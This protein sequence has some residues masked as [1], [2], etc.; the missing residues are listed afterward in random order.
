MNTKT[1]KFAGARGS[2]A[3]NWY[4]QRITGIVL[5]VVLIGHYI[6]MHATPDSGHTYRAVM[7]RLHQPIW[8]I[9]DLS[10]VTLGLWH[11]L[12]GTWSVIRDYEMKPWLT[13]TLYTIIV[14]VAL[15]FWFLGLNTILSF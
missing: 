3:K 14:I 4:M 5:V 1:F 12:N 9:I 8:K 10:F 13:T 15:A 2:G 6:L 7:E 11:G